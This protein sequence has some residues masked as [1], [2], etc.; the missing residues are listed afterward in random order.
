MNPLLFQVLLTPEEA[1]EAAGRVEQILADRKS[2]EKRSKEQA[3]VINDLRRWGLY[4]LYEGNRVLPIWVKPR[5]IK[6]MHLAQTDEL[7]SKFYY[8]GRPIYLF[9]AH[10][11]NNI[12]ARSIFV[13]LY[14]EEKVSLVKFVNTTVDV[15]GEVV[16]PAK[17][18]SAISKYRFVRHY[19]KPIEAASEGE[20]ELSGDYVVL[21]LSL[22]T[23]YGAE[24]AGIPEGR[25]RDV[26][27][28]AWETLLKEQGYYE[29]WR[30][31]EHFVYGLKQVVE[32]MP[33]KFRAMSLEE[34]L[35]YIKRLATAYPWIVIYEDFVK[36]RPEQWERYLIEINKI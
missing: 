10:L 19:L 30:R 5:R 4:V 25:Y 33:E 27:L 2:G 28:A 11:R 23:L 8:T 17:V 35:K 1:R 18:L 13:R 36:Y 16:G 6:E 9:W 22:N 32:K 24:I 26:L 3:K 20:V 12:I 29:Q 31:G 7:T 34:H 14:K 15:V 21:R